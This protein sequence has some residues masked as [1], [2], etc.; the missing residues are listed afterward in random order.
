MNMV[1]GGLEALRQWVHKAPST[2]VWRAM[3]RVL[4]GMEGEPLEVGL[5]YVMDHLEGWPDDIERS[6]ECDVTR[7]MHSPPVWWPT[8]VRFRPVME[9]DVSTDEW[10][11]FAQCP[12]LNRLGPTGFAAPLRSKASQGQEEE[13]QASGKLPHPLSCR[14]ARYGWDGGIDEGQAG[15]AHHPDLRGGSGISPAARYRDVRVPDTNQE[16][17]R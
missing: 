5:Q 10:R 16:S 8:V 1:Q 11:V 2:R 6:F 14:A 17:V 12:H 4:E 15:D 13:G 3:C 9:A 7:W